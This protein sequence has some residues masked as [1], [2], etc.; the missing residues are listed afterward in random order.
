MEFIELYRNQ[1]L[2]ACMVG[3]LIGILVSCRFAWLLLILPIGSGLLSLAFT[4]N[5]HDFSKDGFT[6]V[7]LIYLAGHCLIA[8]VCFGPFGLAC[9]AIVW[10]LKSAI[11]RKG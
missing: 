1:I 7:Q 10:A 8:V 6:I 9:G 2:A 3:C 5:W 4:G 11:L